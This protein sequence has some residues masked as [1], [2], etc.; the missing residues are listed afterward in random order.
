ME[1]EY[2]WNQSQLQ[3]KAGMPP[4]VLRN[5]PAKPVWNGGVR[6]LRHLQENSPEVVADVY[7]AR[8]EG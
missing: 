1:T 4:E 5:L 8:Q 6:K 3:Q 2:D 7:Q